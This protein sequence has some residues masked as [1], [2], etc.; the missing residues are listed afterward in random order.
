MC[1][2]TVSFRVYLFNLVTTFSLRSHCKALYCQRFLRA[3]FCITITL[4]SL[5]HSGLIF[6]KNWFLLQVLH[7]ITWP[8]RHLSH[9]LWPYT[10]HFVMLEIV[11][12]TTGGCLCLLE[13]I[14][15]LESSQFIFGVSVSFLSRHL[16]LRSIY[17]YTTNSRLDLLQ[18]GRIVWKNLLNLSIQILCLIHWLVWYHSLLGRLTKTSFIYISSPS[19]LQVL[20]RFHVVYQHSTLVFILEFYNIVCIS[21]L[22]VWL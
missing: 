16:L 3:Q 2:L 6:R 12:I 18:V 10:Y 9:I 4:L 17:S 21:D 15:C 8:T 14:R 13:V 19:E 1:K 22:L 11:S 7:L 20:L 5:E